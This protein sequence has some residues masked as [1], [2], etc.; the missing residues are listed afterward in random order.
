MHYFNTDQA[1]EFEGL[2][3]EVERTIRNLKDI[4]LN[5]EAEVKRLQDIKK[6][7]TRSAAEGV[8]QY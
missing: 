8:E 5:V 7:C 1:I 2:Y 4:E 6:S 3:H